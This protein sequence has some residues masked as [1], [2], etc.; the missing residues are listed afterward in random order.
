MRSLGIEGAWALEPKVFP[1]DRGSFHEWYRAAEFREATGYDLSLAQANCSVSRW[2][3][4]RGVHFS[5]VPPGQ[6]KYVTCLRGAVLDVVVDIRVGS[7][8]FGRWEALRLD[9]D[10]HHAVFLAEGLGHA[11]MA[12]TDDATVAYLCSTGYAPEREHGVH[13]LDPD[14]GI[15]WPEHIAPILSP[16]DAQAPSLA[17]AR[18][19]GL[20]PSYEACSAHY[21]RMRAGSGPATP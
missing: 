4:L 12:L 18:E 7:P 15:T 3:V 2:G 19:A 17:E 16:K 9:D 10:G 6:A 5:D 13:P 14:L 20:L 11:F 1:D 21:A 8:T